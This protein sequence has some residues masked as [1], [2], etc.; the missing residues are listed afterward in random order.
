M[1]RK[2][3]ISFLILGFLLLSLCIPAH[4]NAQQ[5]GIKTNLLYWATTTPNVGLEWRIAP[6]YTLSATVGYNAFNLLNRTNEN[7][8]SVNPKLHHWL[9]MPEGKYWFC[10]AFERHYV[11]VHL[12]YGRYNVGGVRFPSFLEDERYEGWA[13]GIGVS[14]GYQWAIGKRWGLEASLGIG[15][16]YLDY[17]KYNCGACGLKIGDYQR[18]YFGP[19]KAAISFIYYIR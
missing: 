9:I 5:L 7:G 13:S 19:T 18:H 1:E 4:L 10:K 2:T 16:L 11:G 8:V 15:Y 12:L 14:Y 6:H 3:P 17:A